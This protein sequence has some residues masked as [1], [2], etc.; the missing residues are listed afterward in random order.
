MKKWLLIIAVILIFLIG[1]FY[2]QRKQLLEIGTT[3]GTSKSPH[4]R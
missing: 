2:T 4:K 3:H 1:L